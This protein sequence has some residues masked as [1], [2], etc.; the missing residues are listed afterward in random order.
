MFVHSCPCQIY[1]IAIFLNRK[2]NAEV[3]WSFRWL[4]TGHALQQF[5]K[6]SSIKHTRRLAELVADISF[7]SLLCLAGFELSGY[8]SLN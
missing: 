8:S 1:N 5:L 6:P 7:I 4:G 3:H 2:L